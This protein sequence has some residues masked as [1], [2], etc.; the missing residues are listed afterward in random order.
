MARD[1]WEDIGKIYDPFSF[2]DDDEDGHDRGE[3]LEA[4]DFED[5][6]DEYERRTFGTGD[7]ADDEEGE[8]D[9]EDDGA[10]DQAAAGIAGAYGGAGVG[11]CGA[12]GVEAVGADGDDAGCIGEGAYKALVRRIE[13]EPCADEE[14]RARRLNAA[15][16]LC[17]HT[18]EQDAEMRRRSRFILRNRGLPAADYL[19]AASGFEIGKA[20]WGLYPLPADFAE[21]YGRQVYWYFLYENLLDCDFSPRAARLA[22]GVRAVRALRRVRQ[23]RDQADGRYAPL[24]RP[25]RSRLRRLPHPAVRLLRGAPPASPA[26]SRGTAKRSRTGS[27]PTVREAVGCGQGDVAKELVEGFLAAP[28]IV[29]IQKVRT[30]RSLVEDRASGRFARARWYR[31][32]LLPMLRAERGKLMQRDL[33][34]FERAVQ[35]IFEEEKERRAA[36]EARAYAEAARERDA[37]RAA[38]EAERAAERT[39]AREAA[40]REREA[41][42]QQRRAEEEARRARE[43]EDEA[44]YRCFAVYIGGFGRVYSYRAEEEYR[45]GE[46]VVVPVGEDGRTMEGTVVGE[47][48]ARRNRPPL[49]A[50]T[51]QVYPA[52]RVA[53]RPRTIGEA[54][55][56]DRANRSRKKNR[57]YRSR[58]PAPQNAARARCLF[59]SGIVR[60]RGGARAVRAAP[61]ARGRQ[62]TDGASPLCFPALLYRSAEMP[63]GRPRVCF[64]QRKVSSVMTIISSTKKSR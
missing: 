59:M 54:P 57:T 48:R 19:S 35:G 33:P 62:L 29:P 8:D 36:E 47:Q 45:L 34:R 40:W 4:A 53:R 21:N 16:M 9:E 13:A 20:V 49:P 5:A 42:R 14:V 10:A 60:T 11:A 18:G 31:D 28:R 6:V 63:G 27:S 15:F 51:A 30:L 52:P 37:R 1:F 61:L 7:C 58:A 50:R 32:A 38:T 55:A 25:Y 64:V 56:T 2:F 22:V 17:Y 43:L 44:E 23:V 41:R 26:R 3:A 46:R 12:A 24:R 39:A